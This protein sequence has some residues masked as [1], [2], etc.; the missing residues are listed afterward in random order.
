M[1]DQK[2]EQSPNLLRAAR[3]LDELMD[4]INQAHQ[5]GEIDAD[6]R[7]S[8]INSMPLDSWTA[9]NIAGGY[10]V[11][12]EQAANMAPLVIHFPNATARKHF[13]D[14]LDSSHAEDGYAIWMDAR[15]YEDKQTQ[16]MTVL[17]KRMNFKQG[18]IEVEWMDSR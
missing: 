4:T 18:T 7:Y 17:R 14:W 15:E 12:A 5:A 9:W 11:F 2:P 3:L 10:T 1:E 16:E 6:E 13:M 8:F